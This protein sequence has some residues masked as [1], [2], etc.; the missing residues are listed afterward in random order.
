[1]PVPKVTD[2]EDGLA[3]KTSE[4]VESQNA[5]LQ[6]IQNASLKILDNPD[7]LSYETVGETNIPEITAVAEKIQG[8]DFPEN[9]IPF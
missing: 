6:N 9:N 4:Y 7:I 5:A 3:K 8:T 2:E 1:M